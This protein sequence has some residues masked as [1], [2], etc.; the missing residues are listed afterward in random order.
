MS[1]NQ[2]KRKPE[3]SHTIKVDKKTQSKK[4][5]PET[6]KEDQSKKRKTEKPQFTKEEYEILSIDFEIPPQTIKRK[7][8]YNESESN[9]DFGNRNNDNKNSDSD[10]ENLTRKQKKKEIRS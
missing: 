10:F 7:K 3:K 2:K 9:E 8:E 6:T 1:L 4:L 5:K